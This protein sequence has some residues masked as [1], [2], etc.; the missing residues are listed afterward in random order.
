MIQMMVIQ[1]MI[2]YFHLSLDETVVVVVVVVVVLHPCCAL[3]TLMS[4]RVD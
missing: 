2:Q 4:R 3:L 1:M